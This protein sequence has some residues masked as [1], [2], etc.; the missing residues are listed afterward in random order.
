MSKEELI[1]GVGSCQDRRSAAK[2]RIR[3]EGSWCSEGVCSFRQQEYQVILELSSMFPVKLLCE[4]M[5]I[6]RSSFYNWKAHLSKPSK[7]GKSAGGGNYAVQGIPSEVSV[8]WLSLA[9]CKDISGYRQEDVGSV[10]AQM[11]QGNRYQESCE[12]LSV[13]KNRG[14]RT[15]FSRIC[16]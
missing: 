9:E 14:I 11:L 16:P 6:Q 3:S 4:M 10:C 15:G 12:A 7:A 2:K 1:Q 13:Q 5:G 8:A